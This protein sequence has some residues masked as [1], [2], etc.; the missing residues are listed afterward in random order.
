MA[1][2]ADGKTPH[3][4]LDDDPEKR[5]AVVVHGGNEHD[6]RDMHRSECDI[7]GKLL[8]RAVLM[9]MRISGQTSRAET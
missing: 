6:Y 7:D 9:V 8:S 4:V 1:A 2:Q 3:E 5:D